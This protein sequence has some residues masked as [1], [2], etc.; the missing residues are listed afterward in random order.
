MWGWLS[1]LAR[2]PWGLSV[3]IPAE[4]PCI[5]CMTTEVIFLLLL[6]KQV[7]TIIPVQKKECWDQGSLS[8]NLSFWLTYFSK[9]LWDSGTK[10]PRQ[11]LRV[12]G[13]CFMKDR[14]HLCCPSLSPALVLATAQKC[15]LSTH[16][17]SVR[18]R[19]KNLP[20]P[21]PKTIIFPFLAPFWTLL[22]FPA[23]KRRL[24]F[25]SPNL[26]ILNSVS[27]CYDFPWACRL[28]DLL[29]AMGDTDTPQMWG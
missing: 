25:P 6:S 4:A 24:V 14:E 3:M 9:V 19:Y 1:P 7:P 21:L 2:L 20:S 27:R 23:V 29:H 28:F 17:R 11:S 10:L 12:T 13:M 22:F 26:L 5:L 18:L 8:L 15:A 16:S